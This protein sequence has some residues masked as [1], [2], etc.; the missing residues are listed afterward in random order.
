MCMMGMYQIDLC[1]VCWVDPQKLCA[2]CVCTGEVK[3]AVV[4]QCMKL[5]LSAV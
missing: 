3:D 4:A 1:D 5:D 2:S